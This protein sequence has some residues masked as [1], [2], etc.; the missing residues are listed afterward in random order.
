MCEVRIPRLVNMKLAIRILYILRLVTI[1]KKS[2]ML[3]PA[4]YI[5]LQDLNSIARATRLVR[6]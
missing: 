4:V 3:D 1:T 2:Q 6:K 5:V